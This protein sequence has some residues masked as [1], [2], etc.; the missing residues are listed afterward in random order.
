[1]IFNL[2]LNLLLRIDKD[3]RTTT[4]KL[5]KYFSRSILVNFFVS[6]TLGR[7]IRLKT[8]S[9]LGPQLNQSNS[10]SAIIKVEKSVVRMYE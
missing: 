5:S 7:L 3:Q 9:N 6:Y 10:L 4:E 8:D 2:H 1:M